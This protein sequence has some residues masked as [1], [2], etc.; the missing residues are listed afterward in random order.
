MHQDGRERR[1]R[2]VIYAVANRY[3]VLIES[4]LLDA[5][6]DLFSDPVEAV[7]EAVGNMRP[8]EIVLN[9]DHFMG[10]SS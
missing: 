9:I 6:L 4:E 3:N 8:D 2:G 10:A 1:R 7:G 5:L